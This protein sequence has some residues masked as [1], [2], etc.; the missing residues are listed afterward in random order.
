ML[1]RSANW[2]GLSCPAPLTDTATVQLAHGGGGRKM[3]G[4]VEGLLLPAM[5]GRRRD[6]LP[7]HDSAILTAGE[8]RLAFTTDSFVVNP[9]F[10]PGGDIGRL[11]VCGT[12]NDLAMAGATPQ[13]LSC[14]LVLEEGF[15]LE[16]LQRIA[17]SMRAAADEAGVAIVTGDTKV[18]DH[19]KAD[20]VFITTA[21]V[22]LVP[23][24]LDVRPDRVQP[25]DLVLLS[26]DVGRHGVAIMATR[27]GLG[28]E[29]LPDSD[30]EPL[31][32]AVARLTP[33]G[34]DLHCLRDLTRGGL[35]TALVEIAEDSRVGMEI[36][37]A[38]IPVHEAVRS[39]C[40]LLGLDPLYVANEGRFVAFVPPHAADRALAAMSDGAAATPQ[41]I[42]K[43]IEDTCCDVVGKQ[44]FGASRLL[45]MLSGEQLPRIC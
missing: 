32:A 33:L 15:P 3:R 2:T 36:D 11:A 10:F 21:G 8:H 38:S 22:G 30:C 43:V 41:V 16:S 31:A 34:A 23:A 40:D 6:A 44:P 1:D 26:G 12:V 25:G 18:V 28:F 29:G 19:G 35:A 17:A 7:L 5:T 24:G 13:W 14:A 20:G 27:D 39:A 9:L 37:E 4:L 45:I 42:G